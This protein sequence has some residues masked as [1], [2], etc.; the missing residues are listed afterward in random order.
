M[1]LAGRHAGSAETR[2]SPDRERDAACDTRSPSLAC[3]LCQVY[4]HLL[5]PCPSSCL[6]ISSPT[7]FPSAPCWLSP[8]LRFRLTLPPPLPPPLLRAVLSCPCNNFLPHYF[9]MQTSLSLSVSVCLFCS[10]WWRAQHEDGVK[11]IIISWSVVCT[12]TGWETAGL[13]ALSAF[14]LAEQGK[15]GLCRHR[16]SRRCWEPCAVTFWLLVGGATQLS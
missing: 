16:S 11:W 7:A 4:G 14:M 1:T 15:E 5:L 6:S 2:P 8:S 13:I 9:S 10:S 12:T 3:S